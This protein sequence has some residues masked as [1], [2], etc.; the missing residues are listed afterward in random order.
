MSL[1]NYRKKREFSITSEPSGTESRKPKTEEPIFVIHDHYARQHHHDLRLEMDGVLKSWAVP[2]LTPTETGVKRLAVQVEDHPLEYA[3]FTGK[4]PEGEY[5]AGTVKIFDK[6]TYKI[7]HQSENSFEFELK[8]KKISGI[9]ALVQ[10][11]GPPASKNWLFFKS[12]KNISKI[13]NP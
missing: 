8:G 11:K 13:D 4:I 3:G 7:V 1:E 9:Y 5:G 10:F 6:G 12:N 2:K